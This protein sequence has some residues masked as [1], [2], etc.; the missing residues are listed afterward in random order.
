MALKAQV[1][2]DT[3]IPKTK[4]QVLRHLTKKIKLDKPQNTYI[5]TYI[6]INHAFCVKLIFRYQEQLRKPLRNSQTCLASGI[7]H[8]S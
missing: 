5:H 1:F 7:H 2:K 8:P 6:H 3:D 4:Q